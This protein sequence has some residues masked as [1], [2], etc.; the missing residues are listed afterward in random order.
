MRKRLL[1]NHMQL[2][3]RDLY[4]LEFRHRDWQ[5]RWALWW[6]G[7]S[8]VLANHNRLPAENV[9]PLEIPLPRLATAMI[10]LVLRCSCAYVLL[11]GIYTGPTERPE[12]WGRGFV[13]VEIKR[14]TY[15]WLQLTLE[16]QSYENSH[17]KPN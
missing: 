16:G 17:Q 7:P 12:I 2:H 13:K 1:A 14:C 5:R 8:F 10:P 11:L 3:A 15:I 4:P 9:Y 6:H